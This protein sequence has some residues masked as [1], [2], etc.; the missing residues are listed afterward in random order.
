MI[1]YFSLLATLFSFLYFIFGVILHR[2]QKKDEPRPRNNE[3][4]VSIVVAAKNEAETLSACLDSLLHLDYPKEKLDIIVSNDNSTDGTKDIIEQFA[5]A[6]SQILG[7]TLHTD[8][9]R[10][11]GKAGAILPAIERARG[12]II[13]MTDADCL[14]PPQWIKTLLRYFDEKTGL[15]GGFTLLDSKSDRTNIWGKIQ[16]F[17]WLYLLSAAYGAA[18]FGRPLSWIGNNLAFRSRVFSEIGGS[19]I[20]G[21]SLVEDFTLIKAIAQNAAFRI[22][23]VAHPQALVISRPMSGLKQLYDQRKR[24]ATGIRFVDSF[25]IMLMATSFLS[26]L[27]AII[28][29]FILP[30]FQ[31]ILI[32]VIL[33][34]TDLGVVINTAKKLERL[35]LL[36]YFSL[37]ELFYIL[38]TII[39]PVLF[40]FDRKIN[41]KNQTYSANINARHS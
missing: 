34:L 16:S 31:T 35:D 41:W 25:G 6:H 36:K 19:E 24:W 11:P 20:F 26:H 13:F 9:K 37:F 2:S 39:F 38:Y 1:I 27:L 40:L 12:E 30:P 33:F 8:D 14:V 15:V 28:G 21:N 32:F 7:I 29:V 23:F 3:P 18:N 17:D 4:T 5:Q 10:C 22:R